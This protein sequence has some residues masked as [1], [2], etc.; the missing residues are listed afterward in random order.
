MSIRDLI[1][2]G[3]FINT[4][5]QVMLVGSIFM[6]LFLT[7]LFAVHWLLYAF[8]GFVL[9][10]DF[11]FFVAL[12]NFYGILWLSVAF[13]WFLVEFRVALC[14][15]AAFCVIF[16]FSIYGKKVENEKLKIVAR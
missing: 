10:G 6:V 8:V 14:T 5:Q 3:I 13:L 11:V 4:K 1:M 7:F 16:Y 2:F 9:Y 12:D 15:L